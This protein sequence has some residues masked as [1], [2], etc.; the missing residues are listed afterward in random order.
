MYVRQIVDKISETEN[1]NLDELI[2]NFEKNVKDE[3]LYYKHTFDI[4]YYKMNIIDYLILYHIW[5]KI[6]LRGNLKEYLIIMYS[7]YKLEFLNLNFDFFDCSGV[8]KIIKETDII[9]IINN[10][11]LN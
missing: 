8:L 11:L 7:Y 9:K 1:I 6:D 2:K 4:Q 3:V 10:I 5:E